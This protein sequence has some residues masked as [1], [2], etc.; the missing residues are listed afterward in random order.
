MKEVLSVEQTRSHHQGGGRNPSDAQS[1]PGTLYVYFRKV[2]THQTYTMFQAECEAGSDNEDQ[3]VWQRSPQFLVGLQEA[4]RISKALRWLWS[5]G[6]KE[7]QKHPHVK[8]DTEVTE[9]GETIYESP[10]DQKSTSVHG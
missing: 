8:H 2:E 6:K 1:E 9:L 10:A 7:N 4:F 5:L 3:D